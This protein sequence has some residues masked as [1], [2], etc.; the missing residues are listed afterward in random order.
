VKLVIQP[1]AETDI[2]EAAV[3]YDERSPAVRRRFL[4]TVEAALAVIADHPQRYQTIYRQV[5][6]VV[7][8]RFP[9]ALLYV[10]SEDEVNV[11][12]CIHGRQSPTRW[13]R[14]IR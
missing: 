3:W 5:R 14:R 9:Y 4:Q 12:A 6:R 11:I 7:L 10:A 1:E 8:R 2:V 13:Q